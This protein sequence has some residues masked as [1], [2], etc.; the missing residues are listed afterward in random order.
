MGRSSQLS[1]YEK[2]L[3]DG[4]R[5]QNMTVR[6]IAEHINRSKS[7]VWNYVSNR[8]SY[9][10]KKSTGRP[11]VINPRVRR[12][13]FKD[14]S[15]TGDSINKVKD[16]NNIEASKTSI[17]RA[18]KSEENLTYNKRQRAP[19]LK[20]H[21]IANRL[22]WA[23]NKVT[24]VESWFKVFFSD[25]KKWN[26]DGPD[27]CQYYWHDLRKEESF[28]KSRQFGGGSVMTWAAFSATERTEIIFL[29]GR[30]DSEKYIN[31]FEE[32]MEPMLR[33][34]SVFQQDNAPIHVSHYSKNYFSQHSINL[35]EWPALSPDLNPIENLWG[36]LVR[37]VYSGGKQYPNKELLKEAI[38]K[39]WAEVPNETL[40]KLSKSM[41]KRCIQIIQSNGS[42]ICF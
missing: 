16:R 37:K 36:I 27:G 24:W 15:N 17:W 28:F 19:E 3:I 13:L 18:L 26:L 20:P 38:R 30:Q 2:G 40:S 34:D 1:D 11:T 23:I 9:G 4:L 31:M 41:H 21:H 7:V 8:D 22:Q 25:E 29:E 42:K 35:L 12:Q 5:Q 6:Q 32:H 14:I 10:K 33:A 39:A